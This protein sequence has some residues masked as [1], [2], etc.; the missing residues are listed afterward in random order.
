MSDISVEQEA[1]EL[2]TDMGFDVSDMTNGDL[3]PLANK[4]NDLAAAQ[5]RIAEL[6]RERD[7]LRAFALDVMGDWPDDC[8]VDGFDLQ[9]FALKHGL[10]TETKV[11]GPCGE[12]CWCLEYHGGDPEDWADGVICYKK[13]PLLLDAAREGK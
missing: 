5:A 11:T 2:L 8:G 7:A 4:L 3:A 10:L 9:D 12:N 6:E 13:T 1:C